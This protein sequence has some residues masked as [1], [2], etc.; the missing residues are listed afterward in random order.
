[1]NGS[2][3]AKVTDNMKV[4]LMLVLICA[5]LWLSEVCTQ[6]TQGYY[7]AHASQDWGPYYG[8]WLADHVHLLELKA[9]G[10][11]GL[12]M[13]AIPGFLM[14][15]IGVMKSYKFVQTNAK[16]VKTFYDPI[17]RDRYEVVSLVPAINLLLAYKA[18]DKEEALPYDDDP[19]WNASIERSLP[20]LKRMS[21]KAAQDYQEGRTL[22]LP[23]AIDESA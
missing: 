22:A 18:A 2:I 21:D 20:A 12:V 3:T 4:N 19:E 9:I 7:E 11:M 17:L 1:M 16:I 13:V 8:P 10:A 15:G 14:W 6:A 23:D 5:W